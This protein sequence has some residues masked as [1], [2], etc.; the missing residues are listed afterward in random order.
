MTS[1]PTRS[2]GTPPRRGR[3]GAA[4]ALAGASA[5][6]LLTATL[7]AGSAHAAPA[8]PWPL[9]SGS[10]LCLDVMDAYTANLTPVQ[11]YPCNGTAAQN[12]SVIEA[13]STVRDFGKC[14]D[15]QGG[16][17]ANATKVDLYDCNGTG[18]QVWI[19]RADGTFYNPQ[20]NK[21]LDNPSGSAAPVRQQIWDCNGSANQKWQLGLG[22]L[23]TDAYYRAVS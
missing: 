1:A 23:R 3:K 19:P 12:W 20:S 15:I 6:V 10:G 22:H 21:C 16:G 18:A 7:S 14:L 9:L 2:T 13:G 4:L 5:A 17:T 8:V 11:V